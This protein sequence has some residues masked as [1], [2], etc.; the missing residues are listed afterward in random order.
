MDEIEKLKA[1][2]KAINAELQEMQVL[3][4]QAT[5]EIVT[6]LPEDE[7]KRVI[8]LTTPYGKRILCIEDDLNK[9][10]SAISDKFKSAISDEL[11]DDH[12]RLQAYLGCRTSPSEIE[13][14]Y[15]KLINALKRYRIFVTEVI[16][17]IFEEIPGV[18]PYYLNQILTEATK[19]I[20][21]EEGNLPINILSFCEELVNPEETVENFFLKHRS[22]IDK[23]E[24]L[25]VELTALKE[26]VESLKKSKPQLCELAS[27]C[28]E[29]GQTQISIEEL[30]NWFSSEA[31]KVLSK[32]LKINQRILEVSME[33]QLEQ[34]QII[35]RYQE[36]LLQIIPES[37][38]TVPGLSSV[39]L[40]QILKEAVRIIENED[41]LPDK[42]LLFCEELVSVK[43]TE[44]ENS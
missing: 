35:E 19:I 24:K 40:Q 43:E 14:R 23:V 10:I 4:C 6:T 36:F 25:Q 21:K 38:K 18:S 44:K 2:I 1:K 30:D 29:R 39:K 15:K 17:S 13:N 22:P 42:M 33:C 37:V 41:W 34:S 8:L 27:C 5:Q 20:E 9:D 28:I 3:K 12:K 11:Y 26:Q 7:K 16:P 32:E 31:H